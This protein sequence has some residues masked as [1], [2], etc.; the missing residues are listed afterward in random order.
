MREVLT[1]HRGLVKHYGGVIRQKLC[2]SALLPNTEERCFR[3]ERLFVLYFEEYTEQK[4]GRTLLR[5]EG[6]STVEV[7]SDSKEFDLYQRDSAQGRRGVGA[8]AWSWV[9]ATQ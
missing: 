2:A 6:S 8:R 1:S 9:D 7:V 3:E 4:D 5:L